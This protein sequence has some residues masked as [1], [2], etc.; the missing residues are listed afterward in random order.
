M[1]NSLSYCVTL[2]N[3][4]RSSFLL[5]MATGEL[6]ISQNFNLFDAMSAVQV[7]ALYLHMQHKS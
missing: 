5:E 6:I 2:M 3:P 7:W 1:V 4:M